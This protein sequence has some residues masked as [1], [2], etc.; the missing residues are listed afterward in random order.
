[1]KKSILFVNGHLKVGGVEKALVELLSCIDYNRFDVDLLLLEGEGDYRDLVPN[2]VRVFQKDMRQFDGPFWK[3]FGK[4]LIR[5]RFGNVFY[6][7]INVAAKKDTRWLRLAKP[8]LH[9]RN[10]YDVAV[11]FRPGHPAEIVAYSLKADLRICWWHHGAVPDSDRQRKELASFLCRFDKVVT[12]SEGCRNLLIDK[13]G[14]KSMQVVVIPNIIDTTRI[15]AF[16]DGDDPFGEDRR[17]RIV[18]LSRFSPEKH[19]EEAVEAASLLLGH[20]DFVW[21]LIGDG[22]EF[23][24]LKEKVDS[25]GLSD[26]VV[27][28]GS[29]ANPYHYLKYSDLMVHPSHVESLCIAVLEAMALEVPC[30]VTRSI[31]PESFLNDGKNGILVEKG[32]HA[33]A[34][35]VMKVVSFD[36]STIESIKKYGGRTVDRYFS[37]S[38]VRKM[39]EDL[40]DIQRNA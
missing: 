36:P 35:G 17:F 40:T 24:M 10:H 23:G 28:T 19:L 34:E 29:L 3:A 32:P 5:G 22:P 6:R 37:P 26:R 1:M 30:V 33:L 13:L 11:A 38:V 18:T 14:I 4:N 15:N 12:V 8:L 27:F 2:H 7:I 20:L 31:G 25:S 9:V 16:A 21:L 39:F